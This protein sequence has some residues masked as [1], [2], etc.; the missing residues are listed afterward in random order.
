MVHIPGLA[1]LMAT[2]MRA[3]HMVSGAVLV[4]VVLFI[5]FSICAAQAFYNIDYQGQDL[6]IF[7][8]SSHYHYLHTISRPNGLAYPYFENAQRSIETLFHITFTPGNYWPDDSLRDY[9]SFAYYFVIAWTFISIVI[10]LNLMVSVSVNGLFNG[11]A[12]YQHAEALDRWAMRHLSEASRLTTKIFLSLSNLNQTVARSMGAEALDEYSSSDQ[13]GNALSDR[14]LLEVM[15]HVR[16][17]YATLQAQES[18]HERQLDH[19]EA[20]VALL[21]SKSH[22][23]VYDSGNSCG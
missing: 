5:L 4:L 13:A 17:E 2:T 3:F 22:S 14:E 15:R 18:Q 6:A 10:L 21:S 7:V 12:Q 23:K 19:I 1:P 11:I 9:S 8:S 20:C 16:Q